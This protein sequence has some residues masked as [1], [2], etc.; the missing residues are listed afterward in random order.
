MNIFCDYQFSPSAQ[1]LLE[2]E[3]EM[4]RHTLLFAR[5]LSTTNLVTGAGDPRLAEAE[6]AVGQPDVQAVLASEKLRWVHLTSAGYT[7][8][9]T[10]EF[11]AGAVAKGIVLTNSSGVYAEACAEHVFSFM[12]AQA[13]QLPEALRTRTASGT[14]LYQRLRNSSSLLRQQ[15]VIILGYGAIATHLAA[16]LEPFRCAVVAVRRTPRGDE[17]VPVVTPDQL[18]CELGVADHIVN[19]LPENAQSK[20]F[21]S[22]RLISQMKPGAIFYNIGRGGTVDQEALVEALRSRHLA[23]AW[24]DVTTPE[25]L[26]DGHPLLE[27]PNC[28][29]TPHTAG[30]QANESEA[31]A[32][33]FLDN[34]RRF[35]AGAPLV[36]RI[37]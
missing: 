4:H 33:H 34:L 6:I 31:L 29:I 15:R 14:P 28:Y 23:A 10:A 26:P 11:R 25:P 9:D 24:L 18:E 17:T 36:D 32:G 3:A 8:Y 1:K 5:T 27:L 2:Q 21:V 13:R 19:I 12:L 30:G 16:M 7:R 37:V 22:A 35:T 20:G